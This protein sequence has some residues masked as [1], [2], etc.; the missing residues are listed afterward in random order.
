M[1]KKLRF[2]IVGT[3]LIAG[4]I[5]KSITTSKG[6]TLTAVSSRKQES[7]QAFV[8]DIEGAAAVEGVENLLARP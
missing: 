6:A 1:N 4:F 7:A 5:A 2:G 8:S 3:G